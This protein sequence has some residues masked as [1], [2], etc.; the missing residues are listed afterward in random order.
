M[1]TRLKRQHPI[2]CMKP[3]TGDAGPRLLALINAE[4]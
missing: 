2:T 4:C 3:R 1:G